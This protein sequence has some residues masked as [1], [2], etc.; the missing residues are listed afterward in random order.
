MEGAP[1]PPVQRPIFVVAPPRSG[2]ELMLAA[3]RSAPGVISLGEHA[4]SIYEDVGGLSPP[5]REWQDNRLTQADL[6]PE[7]VGSLRENLVAALPE[8]APGAAPPRLLEGLAKTALRVPFLASVFPDASFVYVYRE[9][10]LALAD[11]LRGWDSG[12]FITYPEL[13]DWGG[14][15][16]SFALVPGWRD[17][18][19]R[20]PAEI[21]VEQWM[22]ITATLLGDLQSLEP[23]RWAV[24]DESALVDSPDRELARLSDFL[25]I[26]WGEGLAEAAA[27]LREQ[28][29]ATVPPDLGGQ[30]QELERLLPLTDDLARQ[31]RAFVAV[32]LAT[33]QAH[34][35]GTSP[36]RSVYSGSVPQLLRGIGSSVLVSTYQTGKL[37]CLRE[38]NGTVNTHFRNFDKPMGI[39][40]AGDRLILGSRLEV[41]DYRNLPDAAARVDPPGTH[42]ACYLPRNR[43]YTGD[44]AIH[45][46]AFAGGELWIVATS[47][48][49]LATLDA[50]H[51]FVPRWAPPFISELAPED[52]CHLNGLCVVD[53][54]VRF[55]TALGTSNEAGGWREDKTGG[56]V[57]MDV[58]SGEIVASGLSMPHS[59]RV[60]DGRLWV[61]ES[62]KG[63]IGTVDLDTGEVETVAQL[64]G[65]TRGLS[66]HGPYAFVGL[67]QIRE[68]AT[69]GGLQLAERVKDRLCGVWALDIRT[70]E[71]AG[72]VRFQDLVQEIFAV[73]VLA[74]VRYPE[75]AEE[76]SEL[77]SRSF[78]LPS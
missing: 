61:L 70:G 56:G 53:D 19:G 73:E 45:E 54:A 69:F 8:P 71:V 50:E 18:R 51:S 12:R 25:G 14:P 57:I 63:E 74:G 78:L 1:P 68:T 21:V 17:L 4:A 65:F 9:P 26:E 41:W 55:V 15:P 40:L 11:T 38:Q 66:F 30:A 76:R 60:Y 36:L 77:T 49:C 75:I 58:P 43:H 39:T 29:E 16:W 35:S 28:A 2:A 46:L 32:P 23:Q 37:I 52:R 22:R 47:F 10:R 7:L 13:P 27:A 42:D 72:F 34:D 48:S 62:G 67:S 59:P 64:P 5:G 20:S 6:L 3:L 31:A 24:A 33:Q 44:I